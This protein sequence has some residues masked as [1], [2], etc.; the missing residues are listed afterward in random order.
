MSTVQVS[1]S[2]PAEPTHRVVVDLGRTTATPEQLQA[3]LRNRPIPG[4]REV[5][6]IDKDRN[7][8]HAFLGI[9]Q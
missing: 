2:L 9:R 7:V 6:V 8:I 3:E 4:L 1:R 5:I